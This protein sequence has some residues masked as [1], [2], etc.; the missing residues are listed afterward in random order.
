[1]ETMS[2]TFVLPQVLASTKETILSLVDGDT[3][4]LGKQLE[5]TKSLC[6]VLCGCESVR[7][8][9]TGQSLQSVA[10]PYYQN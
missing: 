2:S 8:E 9:I 10:F 5:T 3:V 4:E 1:M 6:V 7:A